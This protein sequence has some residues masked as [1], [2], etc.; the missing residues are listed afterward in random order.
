M[1]VNEKDKL[2]PSETG[3]FPN[4]GA[5]WSTFPRNTRVH[6]EQV[7][8]YADLVLLDQESLE[9]KKVVSHGIVV[10]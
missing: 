10:A 6:M 8:K 5:L 1:I 9:L 7:G 3:C 4:L 2:K